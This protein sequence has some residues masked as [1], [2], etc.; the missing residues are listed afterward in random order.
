MALGWKELNELDTAVYAAIAKTRTPTLDRAFARLSR[1][2]D[3]SKLW[4]GS[5]GRLRCSAARG[6]GMRR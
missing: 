5:A 2:A 6:V 3:H 1:A 4:L